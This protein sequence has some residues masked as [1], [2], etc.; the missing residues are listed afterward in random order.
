MKKTLL[1]ACVAAMTGMGAQAADTV[2]PPLTDTY[3]LIADVSGSMMKPAT[4]K[5]AQ[6]EE[7]SRIRE[8]KDLALRLARASRADA[9]AGLYTVSP[10]TV[11]L[12]PETR[13]PEDFEKAVGERLPVDLETVGRMTWA[14]ERARKFF[15]D[16]E[17]GSKTVVLI[18]DGDFTQW[19]AD[20]RVDPK[21]V[22]E[23][24]RAANAKNRLFVVSLAESDEVKAKLDETTGVTSVDIAA[25]REGTPEYEAFLDR[26]F[27]RKC[28][29]PVELV[30]KDVNFDFDRHNINARA[31]AELERIL[32]AVRELSENA[33]IRVEGWTDHTGSIPYNDRLSQRRADSVK[34]WLVEHGIPAEKL[35]AEG[36]GK[37]F[38]YTNATAQG[39]WENRHVHLVFI[40]DEAK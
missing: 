31:N 25:L 37:S 39:R 2:C 29:K 7:T 24:F 30:L 6:G 27:D 33:R 38:K 23:G 20:A 9:A 35:E 14:G 10:F 13:S 34:A 15:A 16:A 1:A 11:Q 19:K 36:R 3:A 28:R 22:F 32:P 40:P 26:V 17:H 5:D 8:A 4:T 18:T 21:A 12:A